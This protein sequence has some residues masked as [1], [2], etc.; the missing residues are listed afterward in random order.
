[1]V[2]FITSKLRVETNID[3]TKDLLYDLV[4]DMLDDRVEELDSVR[5]I[6]G[7]KIVK[8]NNYK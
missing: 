7:F 8:D 1:M 3:K 5:I 4:N 6:M 2:S